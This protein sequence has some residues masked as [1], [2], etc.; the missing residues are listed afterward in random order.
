MHHN[1]HSSWQG[2]G[3]GQEGVSTP[4]GSYPAHKEELEPKQG[5]VFTAEHWGAPGL[6]KMVCDAP[7]DPPLWFRHRLETLVVFSFSSWGVAARSG[8]SSDLWFCDSLFAREG[9]RQIR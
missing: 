9:T 6:S 4:C 1:F 8:H 5:P 2:C 7:P 3:S